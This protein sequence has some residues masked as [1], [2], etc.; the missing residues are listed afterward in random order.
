M[1]I[2]IIG[3]HTKVGNIVKLRSCRENKTI[4]DALNCSR[5]EDFVSYL[6]M[7]VFFSFEIQGSEFE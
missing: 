3:L 5:A 1:N 2:R 4:H 6:K 7:R